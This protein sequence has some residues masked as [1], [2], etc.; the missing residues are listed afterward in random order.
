MRMYASGKAWCNESAWCRTAAR[1]KQDGSQRS[2]CIRG[3]ESLRLA[4]LLVL[5][6]VGDLVSHGQ[7]LCKV[8]GKVNAPTGMGPVSKVGGD[9]PPKSQPLLLPHGCSV[10][11]MLA[12]SLWLRAERCG[13]L[14][15]SLHG[16]VKG[17]D[18]VNQGIIDALHTQ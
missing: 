12:P 10:G 1:E 14:G 15:G 8:T 16:A 17:P 18:P 6:H 9:L 7:G 13:S 11:R 3:K 2:R 5:E 4:V